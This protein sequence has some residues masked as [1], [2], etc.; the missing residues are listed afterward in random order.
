MLP[1]FRNA[2]SY[3]FLG[4]NVFRVVLSQSALPHSYY[5]NCTRHNIQ[6]METIKRRGLFHNSLL[7]S[8]RSVWICLMNCSRR[9]A[10][11][12]VWNSASSRRMFPQTRVLY[13]QGELQISCKYFNDWVVSYK[14]KLGF[15]FSP[16]LFHILLNVSHLFHTFC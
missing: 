12:S 9:F 16:L 8:K 6:V 15:A 7:R 1:G 11:D 14:T 13:F 10:K 2:N 5:H 4:F 3:H